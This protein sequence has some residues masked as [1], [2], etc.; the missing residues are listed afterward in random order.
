MKYQALIT[1]SLLLLAPFSL[2]GERLPITSDLDS[3][4]VNTEDGSVDIV[5]SKNAMQLIGGIL[6]P[7]IPV[8]GVHPMGELEVIAA[9]NDDSFLVVDMRTVEWREKS[10]IP[11]SIHIPYT[12]VAMRLDELGCVDGASD[13]DCGNAK[14]VVAFCNGPACAQSPIAIRAMNR[15]GFPVDKIYYYRGGMQSWTVLGLTVLEGTF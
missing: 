5:R 11:G 10:T 4:T 15:E 8:P 14:K 2:A 13:W 1:L 12:E 3:V 9:L 7:L 6:Q